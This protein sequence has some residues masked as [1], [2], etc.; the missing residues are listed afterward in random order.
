VAFVCGAHD[1]ANG[2]AA[3]QQGAGECA[4]YFSGDSSDGIHIGFSSRLCFDSTRDSARSKLN[5]RVRASP[6]DGRHLE[7]AVEHQRA[8]GAEVQILLIELDDAPPGAD[9]GFAK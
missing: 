3:R 9:Q 6:D 4:A 7:A 8:V 2:L 1:G 5:V